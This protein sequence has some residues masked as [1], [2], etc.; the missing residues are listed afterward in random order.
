ML[1]DKKR[2]H[3]RISHLIEQQGEIRFWQSFAYG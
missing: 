3:Q 2:A 1:Y